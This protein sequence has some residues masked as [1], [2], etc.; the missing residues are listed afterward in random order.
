LH[1]TDTGGIGAEAALLTDLKSLGIIPLTNQSFT[2][3]T[4]DLTAQVLAIKKS[5][6]TALISEAAFATDFVLLARQL[7][8]VGLHLTWLGSPGLSAAETRR[9]AGALVYGT[10]AVTDFVA[11]Q[12]PEAV[13]FDRYSQATLHLPGDFASAYGYDGVQ[14]LARVMRK[15]G[16]SPQVIRQGILAVRGYHGVEGTYNFDRNG[17][18]LRQ[19]T[20]VQNVQG[21][22]HV[23]K[24]LTF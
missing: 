24:V 7:H 2:E 5:G 9:G 19:D 6:A 23:V 15:V 22:L 10:Y 1:A 11:S 20:I 3:K 14:I 21:H 16:A 8:Q 18:G 12:S 4:S 17:D 13:A